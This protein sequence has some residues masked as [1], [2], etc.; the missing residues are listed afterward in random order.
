MAEGMKKYPKEV[1]EANI[2]KAKEQA[3]NRKIQIPLDRLT[4]RGQSGK[5]ILRGQQSKGK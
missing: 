2:R 3:E 5:S 4:I 1:L